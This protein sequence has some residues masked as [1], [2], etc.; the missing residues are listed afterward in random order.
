MASGSSVIADSDV[1][2]RIRKQNR[3]VIAIDMEAYAVYAACAASP[4]P[5]PCA[6]TIKSVCD[7]ADA[8]KNSSVQ[9]FCS[10]ASVRVVQ[11]AIEVA[12]QAGI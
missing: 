12:K 4:Y 2:D 5:Q 7:F 9:K 8:M 10:G 6:V 1:V 11:A 3:K